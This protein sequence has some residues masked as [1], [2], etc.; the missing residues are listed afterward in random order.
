M[1]LLTV[2]AASYVFIALKAFQQRHV[3]HNDWGWIAPTSMAMAFVE[4]YVIAQVARH[5]YGLPLV[6]AVGSGAA[7]GC[8]T[9]MIVHNN[10]LKRKQQ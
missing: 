3:I 8:L 5:G 2:F 7:L 9:A 4:V 10:H 1:T 6:L